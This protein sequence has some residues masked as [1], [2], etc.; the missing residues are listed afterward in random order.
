M[1]KVLKEDA[2]SRAR[3]GVLETKHG[4]VETPAYVIVGTHGA[5]RCLEP[6]DLPGTKTQLIIANT[7]HLW[8]ELGDEGL[9]GFT[10]LHATMGR[11]ASISNPAAKKWKKNHISM[12]S[13]PYAF[14]NSLGRISLW[15]STNRQPHYT[16]ATIPRKL[17][18]ARMS[19]RSVRLRQESQSSFCTAS[20]RAGRLRNCGRKAQGSLAL[21][22]LTALPLEAPMATPT[23]ARKPI[24]GR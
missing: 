9:Q 2:S 10:G 19:G 3:L 11:Q 22:P 17:W 1:F 7:Y 20:C 21:C 4:I 13:F 14:R 15:L 6:E 24:R 16:I 18:S 8:R 5:V 12:P 23:A